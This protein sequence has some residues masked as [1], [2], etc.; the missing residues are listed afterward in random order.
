MVKCWVDP[1]LGANQARAAV[2]LN[3]LLELGGWQSEPTSDPRNADILYGPTLVLPNALT[4][5]GAFGWNAVATQQAVS[6]GDLRVP[7]ASV[8]HVSG[9]RPGLDPVLAGYF[10]LS[11]RIEHDW[12]ERTFPG[13][14]EQDSIAEWGLDA[15]P[16]VQRL[17]QAIAAR[18]PALPPPRPHWPRGKRWAMC[19]SHD[20]DRLLRF[21]TRGFC[22]DIIRGGSSP[23]ERVASAARALYSAIRSPI[24]S[25]PYEASAVAWLQFE[26]TM[27]V[28]SVYFIGTWSR[29]DF[30]SE[31]HDLPYFRTDPATLRLVRACREQGAEIGLH[32]SIGAWRGA[33]RYTEEVRRF[34]D[35]YDIAPQGFRGH[36]WSLNP[37]NP[38]ESLAFAAQHAGLKYDTSFGMNVA[39][40]FR[41]GTCYPFR[42]FDTNTGAYSG[43]WELP[44]SVMDGALYASAPNNPARVANFTAL[45]EAVKG[46]EGVLVLD[47]HSDSLW[48]GFMDNMTQALLPA[49]ATIIADTSCWVVSGSEVIDWCCNK[50]W[51][52]PV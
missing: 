48:E 1:A 17:V 12:H 15:T 6:Y 34:N 37:N 23:S 2:S 19:L 45:A 14:P 50:R 26:R 35:S 47:W 7:A 21:H 5:A 49:I 4:C 22:R 52:E 18:I 33:S 3:Q 20:C 43:L 16:V 9:T 24:N 25:D 29:H 46:S 13:I 31:S 44:P 32:S 39:Y 10:F 38:E 8:I 41:R 28:R 30:P 11:G 40:G 51:R 42:P 27:N 36:Y